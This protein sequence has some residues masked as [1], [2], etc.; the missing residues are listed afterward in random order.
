M[1]AGVNQAKFWFQ[2]S[3]LKPVI[4][5]NLSS[6]LFIMK[7]AFLI[8]TLGSGGAEK[9]ITL[10]SNYW[11][12]KGHKIILYSMDSYLNKPF[13]PLSKKVKHEP[14]DLLSPSR[15]TIK[16]SLL[17]IVKLRRKLNTL[18]PDV[19]V[20]HLDIAIFLSLLATRF[21][22][23][24]VIIYEG[25][26]PYQSKTNSIVKAVNQY[27]S[28]FSSRIILQT[29]QIAKTFPVYLQ[30]KISV[31]YNPIKIVDEQNQVSDYQKNLLR[32]KIISIG[33]LAP[34]KGYDTLI[35][36]FSIFLQKYPDWS[37]TILGEGT[38]RKKLEKLCY[39][40]NITK[41]VDL[42][43]RVADPSLIA[44]DCSIYALSS[45]YEG[46]PNA[47]CEAMV[48]GL[49]VV[50]TKCKF[51]PEEIIEHGENGLLVP[52]G[53]AESM[54]QAFQLLADDVTLCQKIGNTAK[55]IKHAFSI[56][57]V[58]NQWESVIKQL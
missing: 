48:L 57:R 47:L 53:D 54:S 39:D 4:G 41:Q 30:K 21:S 58:M 9:V 14:L 23:Q 1:M 44:K 35:K 18:K 45:N 28:R 11:A 40:L 13:F 52:V 10:M 37:M 34:P 12:E 38:E 46:L 50:S 31:I 16:K 36:A 15:G 17:P 19:L 29:H 55:K 7:I 33:R 32:K 26:N 3:K 51:G 24:K 2:S 6:Y 8:P 27:L 43:G 5:L 56:N 22:D 42:R 20:A 25:T 49:P